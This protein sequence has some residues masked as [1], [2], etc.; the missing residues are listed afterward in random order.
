MSSA[1][2]EGGEPPREVVQFG[3]TAGSQVTIAP[4]ADVD[5]PDQVRVVEVCRDGAI[6]EVERLLAG[7]LV[8]VVA[9]EAVIRE[10]EALFGAPAPGG[11]LTLDPAATVGDLFEYDGRELPA[12][13]RARNAADGLRF[14]PAASAR[15]RRRHARASTA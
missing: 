3:V 6:L 7:D 8:T 15:R 11:E 1:T 14:S 4:L 5:W 13:R 2:L 9:P 12:R 10:L